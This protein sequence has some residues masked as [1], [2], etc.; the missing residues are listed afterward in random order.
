M[1][2]EGPW[3]VL[4]PE[5]RE[6]S[7]NDLIQFLRPRFLTRYL[8]EDLVD[9][10]LAGIATHYVDGHTAQILPSADWARVIPVAGPCIFAQE[11]LQH[12]W[13]CQ[14]AGTT[15]PLG[16]VRPPLAGECPTLSDSCSHHPSQDEA[17][18]AAMFAKQ[19]SFGPPCDKSDPQQ[20]PCLPSHVPLSGGLTRF[21]R[22]CS[23]LGVGTPPPCITNRI[24]SH[25]NGEK[26]RCKKCGCVHLI[27]DSP[28][29]FRNWNQTSIFSNQAV[30][31]AYDY[32]L[33]GRPL[34]SNPCLYVL[35]RLASEVLL[36]LYFLYV[37]LISCLD[38]MSALVF[39]GSL[40]AVYLCDTWQLRTQF[41]SGL[42]TGIVI[43]PISFAVNAAYNRREHVVRTCGMHRAAT[44]HFISSV[45]AWVPDDDQYLQDVLHM[46]R[47]GRICTG[48]YFTHSGEPEKLRCA[49]VVYAAHATLVD[50]VIRL[51]KDYGVPPPL[52]T[53]M[54]TNLEHML[55]N[56]ELIRK[57]MDYGTPNSI[58]S[59]MRISVYLLMMTLA[60]YFAT[61]AQQSPEFPA[62]GYILS[63]ATAIILLSLINIQN[64]LECPLGPEL[65]DV[66]L[67][68]T[69]GYQSA[70]PMWNSARDRRPEAYVQELFEAYTR[71]LDEAM[72]D[73][74]S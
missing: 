12:L 11:Q 41:N 32:G 21:I 27:Y 37:F 74:A 35:E 46:M 38:F 6:W 36:N 3:G 40:L 10:W 5:L 67:D 9:H 44:F 23:G 49:I 26:G 18:D 61:V 58:R 2:Q 70:A 50:F 47:V 71:D 24:S 62:F 22:I 53:C 20:G 16:P 43:M 73:R 54:L 69:F 19:A 34:K 51:P 39:A 14:G 68:K 42:L 1:A 28:P 72:K 55:S 66:S 48:H 65:D 52:V 15:A 31:A 63:G 17:S 33:H 13:P 59:F 8:D 29:P 64:H 45:C 30:I 60:P 57:I 56:F 4:E 7:P 25:P